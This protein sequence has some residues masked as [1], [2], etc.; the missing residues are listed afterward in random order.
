LLHR[1][2]PVLGFRLPFRQRHD[3]GRSVIQRDEWLA[4]RR[5]NGIVEGAGLGH[6]ITLREN[7]ARLPDG[8]PYRQRHGRRTFPERILAPSR[9]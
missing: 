9:A 3:V 1:N 6:S 4:L 2:L 5:W 7:R 8:K